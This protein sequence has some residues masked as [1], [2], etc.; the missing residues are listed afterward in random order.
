MSH[1]T[2]PAANGVATQRALAE[3]AD[4]DSRLLTSVV[5]VARSIFGAAAS[6]VFLYDQEADELV[7][8]AVSGEG[9]GFLVGAR[10]PADR[11]IAGWVVATGEAMTS[12]SL[13]DSQVFAR[14]LAESTGYVPDS[15]MAVPVIHGSTTLGVL[16]VLDPHPQSR[17]SIADLE[18]LSMFADQAALS[19][20]VLVRNR[21]ARAALRRD[22]NEFETLARIAALLADMEPDQRAR[23]VQLITSL[24][25]MLAGLLR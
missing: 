10:F 4:D 8:E 5:R 14:D 12:T 6:S 1:G 9:E 16:Q 18:L 25:D 24:H 21:A 22:G 15:I 2:D 20:N 23:G 17:T 11:G 7:F 3:A 13:R 19:L